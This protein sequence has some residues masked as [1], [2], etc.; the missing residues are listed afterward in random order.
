MHRAVVSLGLFVA[1]VASSPAHSREW[2]DASGKFRFEA[3]F[4]G[5]GRDTVRLRLPDGDEYEVPVSMLSEADQAFLRRLPAETSRKAVTAIPQSVA[6][7]IRMSAV[8]KWPDDYKMQRYEIGRQE[9][10]YLAV[11]NYSNSAAP[12]EVAAEILK[13]AKT[14]WSE[15]YAMQKYEI[16]RQCRAYE[17]VKTYRAEDL[18]KNVF[19]R[20]TTN[21]TRKWPCDYTM[22]QYEI[23]TQVKAYRELSE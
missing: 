10:G 3:E 5:V 1:V 12:P 14:K 7:S 17:A 19:V 13:D 15:D 22:Q 21:A 11:A 4:V 8:Q 20:I 2:V 16:E 23:D 18:P 9:A 6:R